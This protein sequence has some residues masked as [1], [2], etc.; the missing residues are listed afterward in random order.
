MFVFLLAGSEVVL[1]A[2]VLASC[3]FLC[4]KKKPAAPADKLESITMTDGAQVC[5][6][7]AET[8]EEEEKGEREEQEKETRK[9]MSEEEEERH[10]EEAAEARPVSVTVDSQEVE[11]FLKEPQPNGEITINPETCL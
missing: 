10:E 5:G 3:N 11:Q 9:L 2:L 6:K 8:D 7:P 4:I 1:S